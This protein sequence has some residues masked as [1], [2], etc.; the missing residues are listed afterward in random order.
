MRSDVGYSIKVRGYALGPA[1]LYL[2]IDFHRCGPNPA[3]E[4]RHGAD[5][6]IFYVIHRGH[7]STVRHERSH[8][9]RDLTDHACAY[10]QDQ[11]LPVNSPGGILARGSVAYRVHR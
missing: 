9:T 7:F 6:V 8:V 3:V 2:F 10:L 1:R 4:R 11:S 5:G